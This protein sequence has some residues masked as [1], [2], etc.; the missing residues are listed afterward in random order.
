MKL[1]LHRFRNVTGDSL[2]KMSIVEA[3]SWTGR[4]GENR[5]EVWKWFVSGRGTILSIRMWCFCHE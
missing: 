3:N 5:S 1:G 2:D 4:C